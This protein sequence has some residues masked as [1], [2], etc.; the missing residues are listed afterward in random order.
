MVDVTELKVC[1][2]CGTVYSPMRSNGYCPNDKCKSDLREN[3]TTRSG[4]GSLDK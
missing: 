2:D 1:S 3:V 4:K